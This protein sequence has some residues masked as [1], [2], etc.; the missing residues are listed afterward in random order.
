MP[1]Y[2]V[3]IEDS[4]II[5]PFGDLNLTVEDLLNCK[6]AIKKAHLFNLDIPFAT[7]KDHQY[8]SLSKSLSTLSDSLKH[9]S[10]ESEKTLLI[11]A[12]AK[13]DL[14]GLEASF[15]NKADDIESS[16]ISP[17]LDEQAKLIANYLGVDQNSIMVISNACA[18][19]QVAL[20]TG[21]EL[22]EA[23]AYNT[24]IIAGFDALYNFTVSGFNSLGALSHSDGAKPFDKER[25]GLT[26]G[27]CAGVTILKYREPQKG[28]IIISGAG[29]SNDANHRTGPSR[30]GDGLFKAIESAFL[31]ASIESSDVAAVKCHGTATNYND[32]MEAKALY[33]VFR[34]N[35]PPVSSLKGAMGHMSGGGSLVEVLIGASILRKRELPPTMGFKT[36]G[37][38]EPIRVSNKCQKINGNILLC[39]AAGFGGLNSALLLEQ[40]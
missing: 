6:S 17:L 4:S 26:M 14:S 33:S 13:G 23:G 22:L 39:L 38:D 24:I 35:C 40:V 15:N 28:D 27:E 37:V 16:T 3:V 2:K 8:R 25:D 19:G 32:A 11:Y 12:A 10:L 30:T 21:K 18:S 29:S 9:N 7:F 31:D 34:D 20:E 36:K 1:E 5:T